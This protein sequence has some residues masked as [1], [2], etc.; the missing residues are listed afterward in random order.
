MD[1]SDK[2]SCEHASTSLRTLNAKPQRAQRNA[3]GGVVQPEAF[4]S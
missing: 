4:I 1:S 3:E 2:L